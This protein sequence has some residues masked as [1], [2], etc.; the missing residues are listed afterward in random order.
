MDCDPHKMQQEP[1]ER[2]WAASQLKVKHQTY[3]PG[4]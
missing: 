2:L 4:L 3:M 1:I